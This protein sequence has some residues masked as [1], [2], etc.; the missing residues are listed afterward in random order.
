MVAEKKFGPNPTEGEEP[1]IDFNLATNWQSLFKMITAC[2]CIAGS[3]EIFSASSLIEIINE[4]RT[5][6]MNILWVT[7]TGN[8]RNKVK[9]LLASDLEAGR[10][11]VDKE[12]RY[13]LV[14]EI[15]R[16]EEE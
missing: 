6:K 12:A 1:T 11:Y 8:L 2:D 14:N 4:V 16:P 3:R 5:G 9:E 13:R 7:N 15:K 10:K